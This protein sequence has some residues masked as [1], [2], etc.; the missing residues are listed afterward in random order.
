MDTTIF[1][2]KYKVL[3]AKQ[4]EAVDALDGPVMVIAG[5]GTGKTTVLTLRIANILLKAG[6]KPEEILALTFTESGVRAM[7]EKLREIIGDTSFKVNIFTFHGFGNYMRSLYPEYFSKIGGRVPA[8]SIDTVEIIEDI[9]SRE[10]FKELRPTTFGVKVSEISKRIG[11]LKK[12]AISPETLKEMLKKERREHQAYV[13]SLDKVNKTTEAEIERKEKYLTRMD[14]FARTYEL[15]EK[16]LEKRELYDYDDTILGLIDALRE[17][18]DLQAEM[19]ENFQYVLADEHQDANGSQNEILKF[20]RGVE[21][22]AV[23]PPN[24]FVVGD[25]K[26]SIFRFQGASLENFY[27]FEEF[28]PGAKKIDLTHNYRSH[29][30]I[31]ETAHHLISHD[32]RDHTALSPN[33]S[34]E[35]K[36]IEVLEFND[37]EEEVAGTISKVKDELSKNPKDKVAIIARTNGALFEIA[38]YL[39][40]EKIEFSLIGEKSLFETHAFTKISLLFEALL[41]PLNDEKMLPAIYLGFFKINLHDIL[42]IENNAKKKRV[43]F[44]ALLLK[45]IFEGEELNDLDSLKKLREELEVFIANAKKLPLLE[46]LKN[47][48]PKLLDG[49]DKEASEVLRGLF[50]EGDKLVIKKRNATL[51]DFVDHLKRL[52][53][54]NLA[55]I[56]E[57]AEKDAHLELI[58]IHKSKGLEYDFVH[59]VDVTDK[60]FEKS[61]RRGD[62]LK[63]PGVGATRDVEEDRRLLYVAITRAKKHATLSFSLAGIKGEDQA[64][65]ALLDELKGELLKKTK[66][67][68]VEK[69]DL[70]QSGEKISSDLKKELKETFL[71]RNF[72]VTALK[73]YLECPWK[74][75]WRNLL[76][77][78]DV[79]DFQALLGT[80]C[81][82][83]L[84]NIHHLAKKG[85]L[86]KDKEL[87]KIIEDAVEAEPFSKSELSVALEKA[88]EYI[89]SYVKSFENFGE[90]KKIFIEEKISVPLFVQNGGKDFEIMLTGNLDLAEKEGNRVKVIDFKTKKRVTRNEIIGETKNS[91]GSLYRQLQFY[92][93][94]W[95]RSNKDDVVEEGV[96]TFLV[97]DKGKILSESFSLGKED[98]QNVEKVVVDA[99]K[100]IHS[101][102]FWDK[103]CEDKKCRYCELADIFKEKKGLL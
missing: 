87:K 89:G 100:E 45:G 71:K 63:I 36:P 101:F 70:F 90:D 26:Q 76:L 61:G 27:Q 38:R 10:S 49:S 57:T 46:F 16:E 86:V 41:E 35:I 44:G 1:K 62:L 2:E 95:E 97:P 98:S 5:P 33:V 53:K 102:S 50:V 11:E 91:D 68:K 48:S 65:S 77:V 88:E 3:N 21:L 28:F 79:K 51:E 84:R 19:R 73:N 52:Q 7:R 58:S 17:N 83:A 39:E 30:N 93:F 32:G 34:Y 4:K 14:E 54:H 40:K 59:I 24:I 96:L 72:S 12:E 20:F 22:D 25:D 103:K 9:L 29:S 6:A 43:A 66:V 37:F 18:P 69:I 94:L 78:P 74:Y 64:P 92:K 47:I 99:L 82:E 13:K 55:P 42:A 31:L 80:A 85:K 60:K 67:E 56:A 81:H 75:F 8:S 15:Y 23:D